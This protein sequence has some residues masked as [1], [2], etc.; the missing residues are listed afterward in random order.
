MRNLLN[1]TLNGIL[2]STKDGAMLPVEAE[3]A[4]SMESGFA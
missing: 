3:S 2:N 1:G 4:E